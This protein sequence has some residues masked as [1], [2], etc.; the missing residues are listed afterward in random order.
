MYK[1]YQNRFHLKSQTNKLHCIR[2]NKKYKPSIMSFNIS[3]KTK[4][5]FEKTN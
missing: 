2:L 5:T 4:N 1:I 3:Q